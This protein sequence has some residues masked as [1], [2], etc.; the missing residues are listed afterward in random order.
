MSGPADP[1]WDDEVVRLYGPLRIPFFPSLGNHDWILTDSPAAEIAYSARSTLWR[2]P[3]V[4]Y[5]FVAGPA[6]FFA[7][8]TDLITRAQLDWLDQEL[9]RS[10]ARW[11]IVYGHHPIH[12]DGMHG[13]EPIMRDAVL[14]LLRG[15]A[16]LYVCGH[17]HDLQHLVPDG[18]VHFVIAG[19]G[20]AT[21]R[22]V[23]PGPRS[24]FAASRNGFAVIEA[25]ADTL[26]VTLVG[27]DLQVLHHFSL[28]ERRP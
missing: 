5:T 24:L 10:T 23:N 4:R 16:Q 2:L 12:S 8:D 3:A 25:S 28:P 6:Q 15:R 11:K 22:L 20:G 17:E 13:D 14:P 9:G 1:R 18:G 26:A 21:P 7:L 27:D 19:G